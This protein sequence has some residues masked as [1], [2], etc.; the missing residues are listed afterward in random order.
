MHSVYQKLTSTM[1]DGDRV[2][3]TSWVT[4]PKKEDNRILLGRNIF[5][6]AYRWC[7]TDGVEKSFVGPESRMRH[8]EKMGGYW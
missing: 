6:E 8:G 2:Q 1:I 4:T 3:D 7:I 5:C